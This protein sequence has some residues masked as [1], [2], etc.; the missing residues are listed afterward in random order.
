MELWVQLDDPDTIHKLEINPEQFSVFTL[1][2]DTHTYAIHAHTNRV[3][4]L[5]QTLINTH[6]TCTLYVKEG[7]REGGRKGGSWFAS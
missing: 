7:R 4:K 3:A 5:I 2:L 1:G 6:I